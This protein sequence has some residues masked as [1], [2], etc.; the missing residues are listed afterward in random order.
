M[1]DRAGRFHGE[2]STPIIL[3]LGLA[4]LGTLVHFGSLVSHES[5]SSDQFDHRYLSRSW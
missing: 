4:W 3:P 5:I 1:A 2:D